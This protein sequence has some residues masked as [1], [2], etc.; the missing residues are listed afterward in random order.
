ML[1][2]VPR[3]SAIRALSD[4]FSRKGAKGAKFYVETSFAYFAPLREI[5]A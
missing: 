3:V 4:K 1:T 5:N 2:S